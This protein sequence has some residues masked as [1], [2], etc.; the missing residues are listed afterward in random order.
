MTIKR[1]EY[2]NMDSDKNTLVLKKTIYWNTL[3]FNLF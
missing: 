3:F 1:E 2:D